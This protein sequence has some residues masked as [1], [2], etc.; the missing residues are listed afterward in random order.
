MK[1]DRLYRKVQFKQLNITN[2]IYESVRLDNK[3]IQDDI[4]LRYVKTK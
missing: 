2:I 3:I 1:S 4:K